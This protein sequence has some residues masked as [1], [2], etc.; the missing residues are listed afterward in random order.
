MIRANPNTISL[1]AHQR[2]ACGR[3]SHAEEFSDR[4]TVSGLLECPPCHQ[5]EPVNVKI[6]TRSAL[7]SQNATS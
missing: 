6:V 5:A 3:L 4:E 2:S 1:H 7:P